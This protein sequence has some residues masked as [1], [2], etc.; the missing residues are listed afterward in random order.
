MELNTEKKKLILVATLKYMRYN[1]IRIFDATGRDVGYK[2][3]G[4]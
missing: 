2:W 1:Y 3:K 4:L